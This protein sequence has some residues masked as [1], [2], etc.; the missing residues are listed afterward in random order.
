MPFPGTTVIPAGWAAHHKPVTEGAMGATCRITT[1]GAGGWNPDTGATGPG[2]ET[3]LYEGKCRIQAQA[4][5]P[6]TGDAAGQLVTQHTY[7]VVIPSDQ[8][9]IP[10]GDAGAKVRVLTVDQNGDA[11]LPGRILTV[12]DARYS[13]LRWER[14]LTCIDDHTNQEAP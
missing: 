8:P 7:L 13:S 11:A 10:T 4:T 5:T 14:D 3:V 6:T 9:I 2:A 12:S 1:G